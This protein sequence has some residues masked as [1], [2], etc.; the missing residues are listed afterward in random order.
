MFDAQLYDVIFIEIKNS[1]PENLESVISNMFW[2]IREH[3][4][5]FL[6]YAYDINQ[7]KAILIYDKLIN[8]NIDLE[9]EMIKN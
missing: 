3:F 1:Y 4:K 8:P 2:K 5:G 6:A 9:I 7:Y